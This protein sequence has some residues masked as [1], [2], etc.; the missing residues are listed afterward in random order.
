MQSQAD[1][2]VW[3]QPVPREIVKLGQASGNQ[4]HSLEYK[5]VTKNMVEIDSIIRSLVHRRIS[6]SR[7]PNWYIKSSSKFLF[8][9]CLGWI[10]LICFIFFVLHSQ[11]GNDQATGPILQAVKCLICLALFLK[12]LFLVLRF[13]SS[14]LVNAKGS[15][16]NL[17]LLRVLF[18]KTPCWFMFM[19]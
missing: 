6:W 14:K 17:H 19:D 7:S 3:I 2:F 9:Q 12:W 16:L 15:S 18:P 5:T 1:T 10:I 11:L 4:R 13:H 8:S